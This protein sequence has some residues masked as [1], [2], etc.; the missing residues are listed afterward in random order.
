MPSRC[1]RSADR[2]DA[3]IAAIKNCD[4]S[5]DWLHDPEEEPV[6]YDDCRKKVYGSS[7]RVIGARHRRRALQ[8]EM[9][10]AHRWSEAAEGEGDLDEI[11]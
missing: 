5:V 9:D 11:D 10:Y 6:S 2:S 1:G 7:T 3:R 8:G 4:L